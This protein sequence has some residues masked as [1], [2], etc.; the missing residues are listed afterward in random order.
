[1]GGVSKVSLK[2]EKQVEKSATGVEPKG[3]EERGEDLREI[4][5]R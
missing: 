4:D 3:R 5:K 1:M 2:E